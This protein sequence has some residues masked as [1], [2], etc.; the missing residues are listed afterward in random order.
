MA[1]YRGRDTTK[2]VV[3]KR[4]V[5]TKIKHLTDK[6][7]RSHLQT[8]ADAANDLIRNLNQLE[9]GS[10]GP[11][12]GVDFESRDDNQDWDDIDHEEGGDSISD[13]RRLL[14]DMTSTKK[15]TN[16]DNRA[17]LAANWAKVR[18]KMLSLATGQPLTACACNQ[19]KEKSLKIICLTGMQTFIPIT[20]FHREF[21]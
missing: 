2:V 8:E 11:A 14:Q 17:K 3:I 7:P 16:A 6:K 20:I 9:I 15:R 1:G 12:P 4:G 10:A 5:R 18:P 21:I 13:A 19:Y